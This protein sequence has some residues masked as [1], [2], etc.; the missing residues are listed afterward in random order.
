[1]NSS[2]RFFLRFLKPYTLQT[3]LSIILGFSGAIFNGVSTALIVP[4]ILNLVGQEI[5]IKQAPPILRVFMHPFDGIANNDTRIIMMAVFLV[6]AIL[7]KNLTAYGSSLVSTAL[8]RRMLTDMREE[9][10]KMLLN[11]DLDFFVKNQLGNILNIL[12]GEIQRAISVISL[13]RELITVVISALLFGGILISLSWQLTIATALL[14]AIVL[15]LNRFSLSM[16]KKFGKELS[17]LGSI[18]NIKLLEMMGGIRLVKSTGRG[19]G[20]YKNISLLLREREKIDYLNNA[21]TSAIGPISEISSIVVLLIIIF[22]GRTIFANSLAAYSTVMLTYFIVLFR[23]LPFINRLNGIRTALAGSYPSL[24]IVHDFLRLDNK[25]MMTYGSVLFEG[26]NQEIHFNK[27]SFSYPQ[28]DEVVL[29]EIDLKLRKGKTLALVG[30]SGS[31]KTTLADLLPRFYDPI[32]GR[33][34]LDGID[35]REFDPV[36]LRR[37]MGIVSQDTFLFN[38][39][40]RSNIAYAHPDASDEEIFI[41]AKQANAYEFIDRLPNKFD[42]LIGDRGVLLSGGQKQRLSIARALLQ[43]PQILILDEATSALDT[44][45]EKLVQAA[46]E[47]LSKDRT[48]LVIAHRLS[49]ISRA[50]QIAV[51]DHGKVVEIGTHDEL[52]Q[53]QGAYYRLYSLQFA[54]QDDEIQNL[55]ADT[56]NRFSHEVRTNLNSLIISLQLLSDDLI[57]IPQEQNELLELSFTSAVNL[58]E[59]LEKYERLQQ[60]TPSEES[61]LQNTLI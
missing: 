40:I 15:Y 23:L 50:D 35:L 51:L 52:L 21:M 41:A 24:D 10:L 20:E 54:Q 53:K 61:M 27:I 26:L 55:V 30:S 17:R 56:Q 34:T 48:T 33:I 22:L 37:S 49:T 25:P 29:K 14:L 47:N 11:V 28:H 7:V 19:D 32:E 12:M 39:S 5:P 4:I 13:W 60:L 46:I 38:A 6:L 44:V 9:G 1:M 8:T 36:T 3:L 16:A 59:K 45:S 2:E 42:T 43:N 58:I 18:V 31:G 57:D